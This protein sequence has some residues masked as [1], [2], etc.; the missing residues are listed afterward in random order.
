MEKP[1]WAVDHEKEDN[2]R[3]EELNEK[4]DELIVLF[5]PIS[6]TYT[7]VTTLGRWGKALLVIAGLILGVMAGVKGLK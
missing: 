7:A 1:H 4:M 3:F 6:A 5:K 2:R